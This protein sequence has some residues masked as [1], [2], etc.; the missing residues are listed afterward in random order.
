MVL[1]WPEYR[2]LSFWLVVPL[3]SWKLSIS[4]G[5]CKVPVSGEIID[6]HSQIC[7]CLPSH[8]WHLEWDLTLDVGPRE[9]PEASPG[10]Q[11]WKGCLGSYWIVLC[12]ADSHI[13]SWSSHHCLP[14]NDSLTYL[15]MFYSLLQPGQSSPDLFSR[16]ANRTIA[17]KKDP[18]SPLFLKME[19]LKNWPL[20]W[21]LGVGLCATAYGLLA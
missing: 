3:G 21:E 8:V 14:I 17:V 1:V 19:W 10:I 5:T 6:L 2:S 11:V 7:T 9:R 18:V 16:V 4:F 20:P 13:K 12:R 15:P